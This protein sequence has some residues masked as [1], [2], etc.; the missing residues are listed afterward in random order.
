MRQEEVAQGGAAATDAGLDG[1]QGGA[2]GLGDLLVGQPLHVAEDDG[3]ALVRRQRGQPPL[4]AARQL[5]P[6]GLLLQ[7]LAGRGRLRSG[8]LLAGRGLQR[9]PAGGSGGGE[10][11]RSRRL[12][13]S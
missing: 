8:L 2:G 3:E 11:R 9:E 7:R 10:A 13:L 5:L 4:K 1:T 6:L 12:R